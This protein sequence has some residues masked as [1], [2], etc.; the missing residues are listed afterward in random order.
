MVFM[1]QIYPYYNRDFFQFQPK[2]V[3]TFLKKQLKKYIKN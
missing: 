3:N 1:L 2:Q